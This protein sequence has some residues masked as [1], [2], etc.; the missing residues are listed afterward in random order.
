MSTADDSTASLIDFALNF[1]LDMA[2]PHAL[3]WARLIV[4]DTF[5]AM[6]AAAPHEIA[7]IA[8][9]HAMRSSTADEATIMATGM[10]AGMLQAAFAN[11]VLANAVD[12]DEGSHVAT[13]ALPAALAVAE[14]IGASGADFLSAFIV[15]FETCSRLRQALEPGSDGRGFWHIGF[16]GPLAA[17]LCTAR[18]LHLEAQTTRMALGLATA[19]SGGFRRNL[20]TMAKAFHSGNAARAGIEAVLLAA[21]GF[22]SDADLLDAPMGFLASVCAPQQPLRAALLDL[23]KKPLTLDAPAKIKVMPICTPIAPAVDACIALRAQHGFAMQD[24]AAVEADLRRGSL[25]RDEPT[26]VDAASFCGRFLIATALIKGRIALEDVGEA[27][28]TDAATLALM[29]RVQDAPMQKSVRVRLNDGRLLEA[30]IGPVQ[31]LRTADQVIAKFQ[32]C[33]APV[34]PQ[35][36]IAQFIDDMLRIEDRPDLSGLFPPPA[37]I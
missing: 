30:A 32:Y 23:L 29:Q 11:G 6:L 27:A 35:A 16:A 7:R 10:R 21:D 1:R 4:L 3:E 12:F 24:I 5:G 25:I 20:G 33:A 37:A 8:C 9:A 28:I 2:S 18:L 15:A 14:K 26:D 13:V 34:W 22:T 17:S 19:S 31:R 36:A